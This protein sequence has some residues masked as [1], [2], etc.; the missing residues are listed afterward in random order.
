MQA[1]KAGK[2]ITQLLAEHQA[3]KHRCSRVIKLA[4]NENLLGPSPQ[5]SS[6]LAN[7][8][9]ALFY[10]PDMDGLALKEKLAEHLQC[11]SNMLVLGNGSNDVL[12]LIARVFASCAEIDR[13]GSCIMFAQQAF[14]VYK[15]VAQ[16]M[17]AEQQI[18]KTCNFRRDLSAYLEAIHHKTRLIFIDNPNNPTG[19]YI[20]LPVLK[21][22]IAQV[23]KQI[24]VV[25]DEAYKEY[26]A[27][28][29]ATQGDEDTLQW[30]AQYPNLII[31]RTFSKIYGLAALRIGYA[32]CHPEI[33]DI[34]N[35]V[36]QPFNVNALALEAA[37]TA[38]AD[39]QHIRLSQQ[40]NQRM[41]EQLEQYL[42]KKDWHYLPS[43]AN[44]LTVHF[45]EQTET[46]YQYLL[47]QGV[48]VRP[49]ANYAMPEYLR[50]TLGTEADNAYLMQCLSH[51]S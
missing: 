5:I 51:I 49:L 48:I 29:P 1:Y 18:I 43:Q 47:S 2:P 34:L 37:K 46:V 23:P 20:P 28:N 6:A 35:R 45:G 7:Q 10:Y 25:L 22:F 17:G 27:A 16:A 26:V 39:Q 50:I 15:L 44:F 8:L 11:S 3:T 31:T 32:L 36:R 41:K 30:L 13:L 40:H 42:Q 33:A 12:E 14:I 21:D 9:N 38:L 24:I 19:D 4:S